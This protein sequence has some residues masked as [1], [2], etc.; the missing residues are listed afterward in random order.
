VFF[1]LEGLAFEQHSFSLDLL[2]AQLL[3]P[4]SLSLLNSMHL[5]SPLVFIS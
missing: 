2:K 1:L 4:I 5:A 3:K